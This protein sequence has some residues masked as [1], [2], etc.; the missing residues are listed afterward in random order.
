MNIQNVLLWLQCRHGDIC[1]TG[2]SS[3]VGRILVWGVSRRRGG[4]APKVPRG[5]CAGR[6]VPLP[7]GAGAWGGAMPPPAPSPENF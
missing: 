3:G 5:W 4:E 1:A 2:R 6:G 7:A